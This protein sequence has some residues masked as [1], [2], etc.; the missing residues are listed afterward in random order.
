MGLRNKTY[1]GGWSFFHA[2]DLQKL[3]ISSHHTNP[4]SLE[5]FHHKPMGMFRGGLLDLA[6]GG[7]GASSSPL[8]QCPS[9]PKKISWANFGAL[10]KV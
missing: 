10:K 1:S 5:Q 7:K 2:R 4:V 3:L 8:E 6:L 9:T